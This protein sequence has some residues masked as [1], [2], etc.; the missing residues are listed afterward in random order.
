LEGLDNKRLT[1]EGENTTDKWIW[2]DVESTNLSVKTTYN[3]LLGEE[4]TGSGEPFV[5]FWTLKTL[6]S[7]HFTA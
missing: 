5:E 2:R 6:L 3:I 4:A 1:R 7:S